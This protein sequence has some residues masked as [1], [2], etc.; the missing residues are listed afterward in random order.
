LID[1]GIEVRA[2]KHRAPLLVDVAAIPE[3]Y[4]PPPCRI[5]LR[6]CGELNRAVLKSVR[7]AATDVLC[8]AQLE[9]RL[10][11]FVHGEVKAYARDQLIRPVEYHGAVSKLRIAIQYVA[12]VSRQVD[13]TAKASINC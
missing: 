6:A 9:D 8:G 10:E 4:A 1:W 3:A 2:I 12:E 7:R 11:V 13:R 5:N